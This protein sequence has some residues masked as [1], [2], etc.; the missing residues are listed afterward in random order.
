VDVSSGVE[1]DGN[2]DHFKIRE[3]LDNARDAAAKSA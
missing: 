1:T 2:K 3:F